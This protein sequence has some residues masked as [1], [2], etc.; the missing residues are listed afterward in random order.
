MS[1]EMTR[2]TEDLNDDDRT[3]PP[4]TLLR[5]CGWRQ[6]INEKMKKEQ[7]RVAHLGPT[8]KNMDTTRRTSF[9]RRVQRASPN[10]TCPTPALG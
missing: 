5:I 9:A 7:G 4:T 10:T 1:E 3:P 2:R 6:G 8:I